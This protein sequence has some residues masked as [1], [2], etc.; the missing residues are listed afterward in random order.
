V[1]AFYNAGGGQDVNK[2]ERIKPLG[3]TFDEQKNLVAFLEALSGDPLTSDDH[4]WPDPISTNYPA[5][6]NW[7]EVQN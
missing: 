4:V 1:V 5:I 6:E 7:R 2:D 3:L